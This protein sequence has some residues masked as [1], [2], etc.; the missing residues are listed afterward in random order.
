MRA[1]FGTIS[2]LV[3][4]LSAVSYAEKRRHHDAHSHD[5]SEVEIVYIENDLSIGVKASM[6]NI[7]GFEHAPKTT[8]QKEQIKAAEAFW[9]AADKVF[10]IKPQ[11]ACK[12]KSAEVEFE[13]EEKDHDHDHGHKDK[14]AA[15]ADMEA[16]YEFTC[17]KKATGLEF[18]ALKSYKLGD[19]KVKYVIGAKQG[20]VELSGKNQEVTFP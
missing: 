16:E 9:K 13:N 5:S 10:T 7:V 15:H 11:D 4:S 19:V 14:K 17:S 6:S 2:M 20:S 12:L 3:I 1:S 8:K 18:A